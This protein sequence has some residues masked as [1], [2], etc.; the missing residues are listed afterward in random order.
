MSELRFCPSCRRPL[1]GAPDR[2]PRCG[3]SIPVELP[4]VVKPS[5]ELR[6]SRRPAVVADPTQQRALE[7]WL[8]EMKDSGAVVLE[9]RS[10]ENYAAV[11]VFRPAMEINYSLHALW[12][13]FTCGAWLFVLATLMAAD[14]LSPNGGWRTIS[15]RA[16]TRGRVRTRNETVR[17]LVF[18]WG[19]V[20][21]VAYLIALVIHQA[22]GG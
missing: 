13:I 18:I 11:Q 7:S 12:T 22:R 6:S 2:C 8:E 17:R 21:A 4:N 14:E 5:D 19:G 15:A 9:N 3:H 20:L 1:I 10:K 16:D